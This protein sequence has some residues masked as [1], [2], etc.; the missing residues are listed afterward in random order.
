MNIVLM[1]CSCIFQK[2]IVEKEI[3]LWEIDKTVLGTKNE[4]VPPE[5][6]W[7]GYW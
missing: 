1:H 7:K 3:D 2:A 6:K 5:G 4:K